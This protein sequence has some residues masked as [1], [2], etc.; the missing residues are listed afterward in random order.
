MQ[1]LIVFVIVGLAALYAFW[2]YTPRNLRTALAKQCALLVRR[3]GLSAENV[4]RLESKLASGGACGSCDSCNSCAS[5]N[6]QAAAG[7]SPPDAASNAA[8]AEAP[9]ATSVSFIRIYRTH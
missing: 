3:T 1:T 4:R 8:F 2:R 9:V 5:K 7:A 6:P